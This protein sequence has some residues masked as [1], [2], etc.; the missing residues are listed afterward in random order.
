MNSLLYVLTRFGRILSN[1]KSSDRSNRKRLQLQRA[2]K[3][4]RNN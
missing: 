4:L 1:F 2:A 3:Q